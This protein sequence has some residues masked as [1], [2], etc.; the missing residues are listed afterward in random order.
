MTDNE[1]CPFPLC[2][3][4]LVE[5]DQENPVVSLK[6]L[7][8]AIVR[9]ALLIA[10]N[11]NVKQLMIDGAEMFDSMG[12]ILVVLNL[13]H[14]DKSKVLKKNVSVDDILAKRTPVTYY[15]SAPQYQTASVHLEVD[16]S[17][18]RCA[19]KR[20]V[21][22]YLRVSASIVRTSTVQISGVMRGIYSKDVHD[23]HSVIYCP[24]IDL[25]SDSNSRVYTSPLYVIE[26]HRK[27]GLHGLPIIMFD[28]PLWK[29]AMIVKFHMKLKIIILMGNFHNEMASVAGIGYL[30]KNSGIEEVMQL[31]YK[32][33]TNKAVLLGKDYERSVRVHGL[34]ASALRR[35]LLEQIPED[36]VE[37]CADYLESL[38]SHEVLPD[39]VEDSPV[40]ARLFKKLD[41]VKAQLRASDKNRL[42]LDTYLRWYDQLTAN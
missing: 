23:T 12:I 28:M 19:S 7:T 8:L 15:S 24:V 14:L 5:D 35:I 2:S 13:G 22:D 30:M 34:I 40:V 9:H 20:S 25:K 33:N 39:N 27:L 26:Q 17:L 38:E 10:D 36:V 21:I 3:D 29:R 16:S 1:K 18:F 42:W 41:E 6:A 32:V 37:A 31:I 4:N 11:M